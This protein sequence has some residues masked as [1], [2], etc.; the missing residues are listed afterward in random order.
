MAEHLARALLQGSPLEFASAGTATVA[1]RP[2]TDLAVQVMQEIGV[3]LGGHRSRTVWRWPLAPDLVY[4][5]T[6][7]HLAELRRRHWP[8][9]ER[10]ELLDPRGRG[11]ADPIGLSLGVY[12][13]VREQIRLAVETRM[14]D[15][16]AEAV[17]RLG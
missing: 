5:M 16:R 3:D 12:R 6:G 1:G 11:V 4:T 2:P 8:W 10:A 17:R 15:W 14:E 7:E 13:Q 9:A